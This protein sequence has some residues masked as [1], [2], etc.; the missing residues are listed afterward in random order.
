MN[1]ER[2]WWEKTVEYRFV[3]EAARD[4][5]DL[6]IP[7][8]G[9]EERAGD[10][11]FA[12]NSRLILVEFKRSKNDL[13]TEIEKFEDY[14]NAK[15]ILGSFDDHHLLIYGSCSSEDKH[16]RLEIN[17]TTYF[18]RTELKNT[19]RE[20]L[21]RGVT[22]ERF[23]TYL[24]HLL[25]FK[26]R[27]KR[28]SGSVGPETMQSVIGISANGSVAS[29]ALSDYCRQSLLLNHTPPAPAPDTSYEPMSPSF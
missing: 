23:N 2:S 25:D 12:K 22:S 14:R 26:K 27:D 5:I 1:S 15:A 10:G 28:S 3:L 11:I 19:I 13:N 16:D 20:L 24:D 4:G 6:A 18:S 17:A 29:I 21:D 9:V 7:L 8:S